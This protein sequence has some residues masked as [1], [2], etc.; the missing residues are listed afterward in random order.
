MSK[1]I[2]LLR[3]HLRSIVGKHGWFSEP[4]QVISELKARPLRPDEA[5][6]RPD[7]DDYPILRGKEVVVEAT[8]R[9]ARGHAF[10][11]Q[12]EGFEGSIDDLL[13]LPLKSNFQ[14]AIFVAAL[15]AV[16]RY[17]GEIDHTVHCRDR[18]PS[19]CAERLPGW[20]RRNFPDAKCIGLIGLQPGM[21]ES[22]SHDF[23]PEN[24]RVTDL[25]PEN[26]GKLKSGVCVRSGET[27]TERLIEESDVIL[28]TGSTLVNGTF[29]GI[30]QT[31]SRYDKPTIIYGV[32][33]ACVAA[34]LNLL[35]FCP[36]S[37]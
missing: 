26:V 13:H 4:I 34:V 30:I 28:V 35:R 24:V 7:R 23:G 37:T 32:T 22:L 19:M 15:N 1:V 11:D 27:E 33:G 3:E 10:T 17:L 18:G 29:D 12:P 5:I 31:A 21:L 9:G 8:F 36:F 16:M 2:D 20:L 6:G 14:R 25:N